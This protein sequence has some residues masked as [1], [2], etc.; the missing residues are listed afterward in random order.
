MYIYVERERCMY[1]VRIAVAKKEKMK[2][3]EEFGG[4]P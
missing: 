4:L 3:V 2:R 1:V